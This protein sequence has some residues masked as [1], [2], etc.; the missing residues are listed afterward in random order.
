M[1]RTWDTLVLSDQKLSNGRTH[2]GESNDGF[3]SCRHGGGDLKFLDDSLQ[4]QW[5]QFGSMDENNGLMYPRDGKVG[6]KY[7]VM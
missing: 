1:A 2:K 3:E 4:K 6:T 7:G 5:V